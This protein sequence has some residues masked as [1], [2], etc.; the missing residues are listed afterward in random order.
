[1]LSSSAILAEDET[2]RIETAHEAFPLQNFTILQG[3][4]AVLVLALTFS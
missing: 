4:L 3:L 1:M 2:G